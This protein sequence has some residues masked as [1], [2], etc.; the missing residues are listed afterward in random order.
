MR[1]VIAAA[2]TAV[3]NAGSGPRGTDRYRGAGRL[4]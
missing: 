4:E 1:M 2:A 3:A